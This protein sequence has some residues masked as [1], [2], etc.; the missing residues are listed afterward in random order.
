[1][2]L[3]RKGG[4]GGGGGSSPEIGIPQA[5]G[6]I[7]SGFY[8]LVIRGLAVEVNPDQPRLTITREYWRD[9]LVGPA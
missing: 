6:L 3:P 7:V 9:F 5:Q 4:G 2:P 8:E 1:M